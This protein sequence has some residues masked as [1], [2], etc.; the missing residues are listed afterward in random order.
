M[1]KT[2]IAAL[3]SISNIV[4]WSGALHQLKV[5]VCNELHSSIAD[6]TIEHVYGN[7]RPEVLNWPRV[8]PGHISDARRVTY[9]TGILF[10]DYWM[11]SWKTQDDSMMC[12]LP[13]SSRFSL[14][15]YKVHN[16]KFTDRYTTTRFII[17]EGIDA[18]RL[19][20]ESVSGTSWD[21]SACTWTN[22]TGAV[23]ADSLAQYGL[24]RQFEPEWLP[25]T[26]LPTNW[27]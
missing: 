15:H 22:G 10:S 17:L 7:Y 11:V 8:E 20:I 16:L 19:K 21:D 24:I 13:R 25:R 27:P 18:P 9:G 4:S 26:M 12:E 23:D 5:M 2:S 1:L 14:F 3:A 6:V